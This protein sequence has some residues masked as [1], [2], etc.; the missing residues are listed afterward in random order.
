MDELRRAL[1]QF[2]AKAFAKRHAGWKESRSDQSHEYLFYCPVCS[3]HNLRW[4]SAKGAWICWNCRRT[5]DTITL[6]QVL[7]RTDREGA[8]RYLLDGYV[9]GDANLSLSEIAT[10]PDARRI[11]RKKL[12][13]L[14]LMA[15]P[16]M[17][18]R[19]GR[20]HAQA[21]AYIRGRGITD[22][23]IDIYQISVGMTGRL[24]NYIVFPVFMDGGLVYWQAR[25]S[26]NPP[27]GYSD[28]MRR[29]WIKA[30]H[31]RKNLN[32]IN[33][34]S[35]IRQATAGEVIYNYDRALN[36][37]HVVIVEGPVDAI[38]VGPHAVALLGK[39]TDAKI[40]RLRRM[41]AQ[42][43]TVYLDRGV[44]KP[45]QVVTEEREKAEW[46]ARELDGFAPTYI[47]TPPAELDPGDLTT[48]QNSRFIEIAEPFSEI[49][50]KSALIP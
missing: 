43:Y 22:D 28:E 37:P 10:L 26:W 45:G 31:Y 9:G 38:K 18:M 20:Q 14:P 33:P 27:E 47:A 24:K 8:I 2:D 48:E 40:E 17:V 13:R 44:L 19:V 6:I 39:G 36:E 50:L 1:E 46:I 21:Y 16:P 15:W 41:R 32:P 25:A 11:E 35:G 29:Q 42:R 5:G 49:G 7:E 12:K 34:P 3:G 23:Q 4:N 30:Y